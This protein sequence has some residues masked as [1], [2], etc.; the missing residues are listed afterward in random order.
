MGSRARVLVLDASIHPDGIA[1]RQDTCEIG[2]L[3]AHACEAE[4]LA[5]NGG[6]RVAFLV[7]SCAVTRQVIESTR[8]LRIIARHGSGVDNVD[9]VAATERGI[10]V[11]IT[12]S[13]NAAAVS[14][15]TL[16]L[17]L[18]SC[19]RLPAIDVRMRHGEWPRDVFMGGALEGKTIGIIGWAISGREWRDTRAGSGCGCSQPTPGRPPVP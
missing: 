2:R 7:R 15:F 18:A 16:G 9:L 14:E 8:V 11:T 12:G 6:R 19:R 10:P 4:S 13:A 3:P 17:G 1:M 5:A